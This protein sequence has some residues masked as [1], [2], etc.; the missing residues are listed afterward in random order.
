MFFGCCD[1]VARLPL[2]KW[3]RAGI[4]RGTRPGRLT[5][6]TD[7]PPAALALRVG[8]CDQHLDA[9]LLAR[10]CLALGDAFDLGGVQ[11]VELALV[12]TLLRQQPFDAFEHE[13]AGVEE[14]E[15]AISCPRCRTP[16]GRQGRRFFGRRSAWLRRRRASV[17]RLC[18][19][20]FSPPEDRTGGSQ[21][22][23]YLVS[24]FSH[25]I[26]RSSKWPSVECAI[27]LV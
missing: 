7:W 19:A 18:A 11:G 14:V 20:R 21:G 17:V 27:T 26:A 2:S 4:S 25:S 5:P 24:R 15:L 22:P 13:R 16:A 8:H 23:F 10:A 9:E 1:S 3:T 12:V 6:G